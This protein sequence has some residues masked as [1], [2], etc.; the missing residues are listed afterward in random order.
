M[1]PVFIPLCFGEGL[2]GSP[3]KPEDIEIKPRGAGAAV[4]LARFCCWLRPAGCLH[5]SNATLYSWPEATSI[6]NVCRNS[7]K[8]RGKE[9]NRVSIHYVG[10]TSDVV[11]KPTPP[12]HT[13]YFRIF[14]HAPWSQAVAA[15]LQTA[16]LWNSTG[17]LL[18]EDLLTGEATG[19]NSWSR[20][21]KP[22][23]KKG[24]TWIYLTRGSYW[25]ITRRVLTFQLATI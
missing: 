13:Q 19:V 17:V 24:L 10:T 4:G 11:F 15:D 18:D 3:V 6:H 9:K 2:A 7:L 20:N 21:Q 16:P 1:R 8:R 5:L 22:V 23:Q 25:I 14:K 12:T